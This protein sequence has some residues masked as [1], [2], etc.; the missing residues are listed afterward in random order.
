MG[1]EEGA[2][3]GI[4]LVE[5][6]QIDP[7]SGGQT[8]S[9]CLKVFAVGNADRAEHLGRALF[10]GPPG[11]SAEE[12]S[13]APMV[14]AKRSNAA[15]DTHV[16]IVTSRAHEGV[17]GQAKAEVFENGGVCGIAGP[18]RNA[19]TR[20][21]LHGAGIGLDLD[22]HHRMLSPGGVLQDR[23]ARGAQTDDEIMRPPG[24]EPKKD[25]GEKL[26][27]RLDNNAGTEEHEKNGEGLAQ[28]HP[29]PDCRLLI[30]GPRGG[31]RVRSATGQIHG[32]KAF[33]PEVRDG[34]MDGIPSMNIALQVTVAPRA[35]R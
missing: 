27:S 12:T 25:P 13:S 16:G 8:V 34:G 28:A 7:V 1:G 6:A 22:G 30:F 23:L 29:K 10:F 17:F 20:A 4:F 35:N 19:E 33:E 21:E 14:A 3:G 9:Q 32:P 15:D 18:Q 24:P 26:E 5:N 11:G 31:S 2:S